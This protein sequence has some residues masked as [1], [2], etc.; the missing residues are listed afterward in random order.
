MVEELLALI[1]DLRSS[2][3][4]TKDEKLPLFNLRAEVDEYFDLTTTP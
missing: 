3:W 4:G 2:G 1:R